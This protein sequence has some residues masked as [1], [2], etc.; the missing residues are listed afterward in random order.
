L[1]VVAAIQAGLFV[2]QLV[3]LRRSIRDSALAASAAGEA[4]KAAQSS[5]EAQ[6]AMAVAMARPRIVVR[7]VTVARFAP[8]QPIAIEFALV[9]VGDT[10]AMIAE[11]NA[12]VLPLT[13]DAGP[14]PV[15]GEHGATTVEQPLAPGEELVC[16]A[17]SFAPVSQS[18]LS[19]IRARQMHLYVFGY[20]RYRDEFGAV[21]KMGFARVLNEQRRFDVFSDPDY[22]Y[23]D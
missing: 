18:T 23:S 9:N 10:R 11:R 13:T 2:W 5:A 7:R 15:F 4:A 16:V 1:T 20:V 17:D 21:R 6:R 22:E 12:T 3:L 8:N 19:L 14:A